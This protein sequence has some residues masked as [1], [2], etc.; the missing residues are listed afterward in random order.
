VDLDITFCNQSF[1]DVFKYSKT[2]IMNKNLSIV[3]FDQKFKDL[4]RESLEKRDRID[5]KSIEI[6]VRTDEANVKKEKKTI[7]STYFLRNYHGEIDEVMTII[8]SIKS[9]IF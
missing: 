4:I 7:I 2:E 6:E 8:E 1:Y 9:K 3:D 5:R